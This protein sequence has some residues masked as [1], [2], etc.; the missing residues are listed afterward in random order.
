MVEVLANIFK[1]SYD[2]TENN[3]L[4]MANANNQSTQMM[5]QLVHKIQQMQTLLV[6]MQN[7]LNNN[8]ND[9]NNGGNY[10]STVGDKNQG[11]PLWR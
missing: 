4:Q 11:T 3:L 10:N 2:D 8:N 1:P 6:Q 5:P 9:S 7:N